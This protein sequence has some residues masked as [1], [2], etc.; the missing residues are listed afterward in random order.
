MKRNTW[1]DLRIR[2]KPSSPMGF[3][4]REYLAV[5]VMVDKSIE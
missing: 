3:P 5:E 4:A 1:F 2:P